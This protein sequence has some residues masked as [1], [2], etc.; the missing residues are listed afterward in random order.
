MIK[1]GTMS[2]TITMIYFGL[3]VA[4][5]LYLGVSLLSHYISRRKRKPPQDHY[6]AERKKNEDD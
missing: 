2:D 6:F 3:G 5:L 4:A 1:E